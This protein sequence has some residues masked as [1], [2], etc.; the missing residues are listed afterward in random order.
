MHLTQL[1]DGKYRV[2]VYGPNTF[3]VKEDLK[4]RF[5][6]KWNAE[7]KSWFFIIEAGNKTATLEAA[8]IMA[9]EKGLQLLVQ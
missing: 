1:D 2:D 3:P 7:P 4:Q 6:A 8:N 5:R 9:N